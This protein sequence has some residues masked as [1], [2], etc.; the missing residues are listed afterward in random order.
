MI[1]EWID[2]MGEGRQNIDP[3][4]IPWDALRTLISQSIF[5]GKIDNE[6]DNK[7]LSSLVN[8]FFCK[9]SYNY[10]FKLLDLPPGSTDENIQVPDAK[11]HKGFIDF[12]KNL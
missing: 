3:D 8:K 1:D 2:A 12:I 6:F 7:I 11:G 5:G 9:E 10:D 4:K